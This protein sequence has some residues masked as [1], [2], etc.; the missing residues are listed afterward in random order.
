[1]KISL[2]LMFMV[3]FG[4]A[5]D[6]ETR[7]LRSVPGWRMPWSGNWLHHQSLSIPGG[8]LRVWGKP[9]AVLPIGPSDLRAV[10]EMLNGKVL[11]VIGLS[12]IWYC[13]RASAGGIQ[14]FSGHDL[15]SRI[16]CSWRRCMAIRAAAIS[17]M[18][19]S[20]PDEGSQG[21]SIASCPL[22]YLYMVQA[23]RTRIS[24]DERRLPHGFRISRCS[25]RTPP[26]LV[27]CGGHP[28]ARRVLP[29]G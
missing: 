5:T 22:P 8:E 24:V 18:M 28:T 14:P 15:E 4:C 17:A 1:M 9:L 19:R 23:S 12:L 29:N 3:A 25:F 20:A 27:N 6:Q 26:Q 16:G 13:S 7:G 11:A 2:M 10:Y 21:L